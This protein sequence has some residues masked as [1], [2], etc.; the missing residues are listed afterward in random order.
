MAYDYREALR[1]DIQDYLDEVD[2]RDFDTLYDD[3]F[4]TDSITGN[5]SGSYTFSRAMAREYVEDNYRLA[6]DVYREFGASLDELGEKIDD[7]EWETIDVTIR[8][9]LLGEVLQEVLRQE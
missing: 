6:V 3:M 7:E 8:C 2:E 1:D 5:A 9:Y 4:V